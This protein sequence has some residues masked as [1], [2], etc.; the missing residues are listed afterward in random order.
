M[1]YTRSGKAFLAVGNVLKRPAMRPVTRAFSTMH[2]WAYRLT[3]GRAQSSKYPTML[4]TVTGRKSGKPRTVPV[5]YIED[6]DRFVIAA[7]Y[8]GSDT[9]PTW[10]L[11]LQANPEAVARV[12]E[13]TTRVR[14][15]VATT[16]ER[17]RLW[18]KLVA[19]YPY[20]TDYQQRTSRSIPVVVLT[21]IP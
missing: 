17:P 21:P 10:W 9:D 19:M 5:I 8:S 16:E 3:K 7:A 11:N 13:T 2:A 18:E 14:A 12:S 4:L 1:E 20:F 15:T 6:G